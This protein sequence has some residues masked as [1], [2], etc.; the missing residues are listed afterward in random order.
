V[1]YVCFEGADGS[2]E[3]ELEHKQSSL[4]VD[5]LVWDKPLRTEV[6]KAIPQCRA[7]PLKANKPCIICPVEGLSSEHFSMASQIS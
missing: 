6:A 7:A 3:I 1:S 2:E 4:G 5:R